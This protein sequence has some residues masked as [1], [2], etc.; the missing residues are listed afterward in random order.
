MAPLMLARG[1]SGYHCSLQKAGVRDGKF[2]FL[3]GMLP[4]EFLYG[5]DLLQASGVERFSLARAGDDAA[6]KPHIAKDNVAAAETNGPAILP[7]IGLLYSGTR[8]RFSIV[9]ETPQPQ[10]R[11]A[12]NSA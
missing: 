3:A 1:E 2:K 4:C 8:Q 10:L 6:L 11:R 5:A 9:T 7:L 12:A